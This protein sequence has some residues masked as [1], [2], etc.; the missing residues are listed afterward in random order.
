VANILLLQEW[1]GNAVSHR[2]R[3]PIAAFLTSLGASFRPGMRMLLG[4]VCDSMESL[5]IN[6][7]ILD[8]R[9]F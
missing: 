3:R 6:F 7:R 8:Q 9:K 4:R 2:A 1:S 5:N